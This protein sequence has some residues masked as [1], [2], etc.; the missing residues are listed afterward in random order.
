MKDKPSFLLVTGCRRS[1]TTFLGNLVGTLSN[2]SYVEEPFNKLRGLKTI[3]DVWYPYLTDEIVN[4]ELKRDLNRFFKLKKIPF[5]HSINNNDTGYL[6]CNTTVGKVILDVF[7]NQSGE[8]LLKRI[9]RVVLKNH[10]YLSYTKTRYK[11]NLNYAV[12]KDALIALSTPYIADNYNVKTVFIYRNPEAYFYSMVKQNWYIE[13][14]DFQ[15][16]NQLLKD[17]PFVKNLVEEEHTK[18]N[19][20]I[21]EWIIVNKFLLEIYKK[22]DVIC[23]SQE[24]LAKKPIEQMEKLCAKLGINSNE[25]DYDKIKKMTTASTVNPKNIKNVNRNSIETLKSWKGKLT[26]Q[27]QHMI[28]QKTESILSEL[29]T[30][31]L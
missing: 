20:V 16:Q 29:E 12:I 22:H 25:L 15:K 19:R 10:H 6:D 7:K 3:P 21:N 28:K 14:T 24:E 9:L 5:R 26:E 13:L 27:Q 1:G 4:K 8:P 31:K 23:I 2:S 30:I 17:Y 11:S 18:D